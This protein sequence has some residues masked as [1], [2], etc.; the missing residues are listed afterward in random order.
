VPQDFH[1]VKD[2]AADL[3]WLPYNPRMPKAI[4]LLAL[5]PAAACGGESAGPSADPRPVAATADLEA[6]G[7]VL[8]SESTTTVRIVVLGDSLA[9][10]YG[11]A[12]EQAFPALLEADLRERGW[13][14]EVVNAGVSGDTTAGG[15][16]RLA[17]LLRQSPGIVVI[18]LGANDALR[19]LPIDAAGD[20]LGE[21]IRLGKA[22]GAEVLLT[23]MKVPP[24]YGEDYSA[25]FEAI[26]PRLA[27]EH[28]V[29]LMPFLLA[30][31]G[32]RAELNLADG[33]HPNP[34]GHQIIA[35]ALVPYLESL[36]EDLE[37]PAM[38]S[39]GTG[40]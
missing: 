38:E 1:S 35:E 9:A 28:G 6:A 5:L 8:D 2:T 17:W 40:T 39:G 15:R 4:L 32:G 7:A 27:E 12:E 33:I 13:R 37:K 25:G 34:E 31:V 18:E 16:S 24:N 11:L 23:G 14:V 22:A 29:T 30:G 21:M 19:G 26:Y 10:G 20:N 36:L 3:E